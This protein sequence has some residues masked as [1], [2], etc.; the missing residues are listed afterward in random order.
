ML[1]LS[2]AVCGC[3]CGCGDRRAARKPMSPLRSTPTSKATD[4]EICH[5]AVGSELEHPGAPANGIRASTGQ[6][7]G[8]R[9]PL[10]SPCQLRNFPT[11]AFTFHGSA[12]VGIGPPMKGFIHLDMT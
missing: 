3:G 4:T 2:A 6:I 10:G 1:V 12:R 9:V 8:H 11:A 7:K 5:R